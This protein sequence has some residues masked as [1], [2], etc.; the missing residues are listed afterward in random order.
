MK[1][2][3]AIFISFLLL[4][5]ISAQEDIRV[6]LKDKKF[7]DEE[8]T[9][10]VVEIP[11]AEYNTVLKSWTKHL[12]NSPKEKVLVENA[13]VAINKKFIPK[14]ANDSLDINSYVKEYDGHIVLAVSFKMR[15]HYISEDSDEEVFYPAKNY[16]RNFA[17]EQYKKA[18]GL[19][20]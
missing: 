19:D 9:A 20:C 10:F 4:G 15:D 5:N 2:S 16:V 13:E 12:K 8:A 1:H 11:Q 18:V 3:I 7:F 14:I 17:V 6:L